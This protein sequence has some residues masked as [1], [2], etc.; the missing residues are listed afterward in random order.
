MKTGE[1]LDYQR[2]QAKYHIVGVSP[3]NVRVNMYY[4]AIPSFPFPWRFQQSQNKQERIFAQ[5]W[6]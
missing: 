6:V 4:H 3:V 5:T 1:Q 2:F